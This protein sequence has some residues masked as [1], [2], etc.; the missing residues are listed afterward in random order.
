MLRGKFMVKK[1]EE[2]HLNKHTN[3][4][5]TVLQSEQQGELLASN[6]ILDYIRYM[7]ERSPCYFQKEPT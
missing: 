3:N 6:L 4:R 5:C 2:K 7:R 1:S